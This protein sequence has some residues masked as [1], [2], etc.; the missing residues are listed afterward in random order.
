MILRAFHFWDLPPFNQLT[1]LPLSTY[2]SMCSFTP[3]LLVIVLSQAGQDWGLFDRLNIM[4]LQLMGSYI[5]EG[6]VLEEMPE[7][8]AEY[9]TSLKMVLRVLFMPQ[10]PHTMQVEDDNKM[11]FKINLEIYQGYSLVLC[12]YPRDPVA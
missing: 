9:L 11:Y 3:L 1:G 12:L 7:D 6:E 8:M 2:S 4:H 10:L 5:T